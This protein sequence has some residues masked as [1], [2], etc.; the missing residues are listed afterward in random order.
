[1]KKRPIF[2]TTMGRPTIITSGGRPVMK[3][4]PSVKR[5]P[6]PPLEECEIF[7]YLSTDGGKKEFCLVYFQ[8][9]GGAKSYYPWSFPMTKATLALWRYAAIGYWQ[10]KSTDLWNT[11]KPVFKRRGK[12]KLKSKFSA[13]GTKFLKNAREWEEFAS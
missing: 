3:K 10:S 7:K 1:V 6:H 11:V 2:L 9:D 8:G 4:F 12:D 13:L 5:K